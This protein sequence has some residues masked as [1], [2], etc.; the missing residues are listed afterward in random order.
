MFAS[1]PVA[2]PGGFS[3]PFYRL[4]ITARLPFGVPGITIF[5]TMSWANPAF[6]RGMAYMGTADGR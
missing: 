3:F 5:V 4:P 6:C 2:G 1:R